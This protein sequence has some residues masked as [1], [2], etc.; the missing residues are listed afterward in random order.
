MFVERLANVASLYLLNQKT[1]FEAIERMKADYLEQ[2]LT[3]Y[4]S[5]KEEMISRGRHMG[6]DLDKPYCM[7]AVVYKRKE[8]TARSAGEIHSS[9][10]ETIAK[11]FSIQG[12]KVLIGQYE[13][14]IIMLIPSQ[15]SN[16]RKKINMLLSQ[17][18]GSYPDC[19]Y[20]IG[21]SHMSDNV[22]KIKEL[23]EEAL[24]AARTNIRKNVVEYAEL[25]VLGV[26][27]NSKN[28]VA[29]KKIAE[30][31]LGPLL[32]CPKPKGTD[33]IKTLYTFLSN[34]CKLNQ[35]MEDLSLSMSG[36]TYRISKIEKLLNKELRD[37]SASYQLL[38]ILDSLIAIG[39]LEL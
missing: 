15:V 24:I 22:E 28:E 11:F 20:K 2:I 30:R 39:E 17:I 26:L 37:P 10:S 35:T 36:L 5:T 7:A 4:I 14:Q 33:L 38:L 13:G 1:S 34:G 32:K 29:I 21:I 25:G 18:E 19:Q 3:G 9:L 27:V 23:V 8:W 12:D 6:F 16:M 31:E